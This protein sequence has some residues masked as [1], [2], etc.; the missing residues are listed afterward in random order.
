MFCI[1]EE[2]HSQLAHLTSALARHLLWTSVLEPA[3]T[4]SIV[5]IGVSASLHVIC[6]EHPCKS[7]LARHL[8]WTSVLEPAC[9]S[10]VVDIRVSASLH[11]Q[12]ARHMFRTSVRDSLHVIY[13]WTLVRASKDNLSCTSSVVQILDGECGGSIV[14]CQL[15][16]GNHLVDGPTDRQTDR[17]SIN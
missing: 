14:V 17:H 3:C 1:V 9:T 13:L 4:S 10:S 8:F 6:C 2:I 15:S 12:L 7:Q 5:D 16:F 11:S